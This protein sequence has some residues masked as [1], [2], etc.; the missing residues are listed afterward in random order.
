MGCTMAAFTRLIA[1]NNFML[2]A[3]FN[4]GLKLIYENI[5]FLHNSGLAQLK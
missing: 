5:D 2:N 4:E 3:L 1:D